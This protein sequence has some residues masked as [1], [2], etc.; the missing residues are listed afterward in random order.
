MNSVKQALRAIVAAIGRSKTFRKAYSAAILL[1]GTLIGQAL[2]AGTLTGGVAAAALGA[3]L[4]AG[5]AVY[6]VPNKQD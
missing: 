3:A 6:R 2:L 5:L 1:F 4:L